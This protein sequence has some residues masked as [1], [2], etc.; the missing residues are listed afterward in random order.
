MHFQVSLAQDFIVQL[1]GVK[2][3]KNKSETTQSYA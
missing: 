2:L 1:Q 3:T